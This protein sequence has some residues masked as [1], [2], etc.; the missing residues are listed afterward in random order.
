MAAVSSWTEIHLAARLLQVPPER[1]EG[2]VTKR[3]MVSPKGAGKVGGATWS[4]KSMSLTLS[5]SLVSRTHPTAGSPDLCQWKVPLM[6][7]NLGDG[8]WS[9]VSALHSRLN[10]GAR[11]DAL[12]KTLYTRLFTWLL[13]QISAQLS[14]PREADSVATIAVVDAFGFEVTP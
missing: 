11:R 12:A 14:P 6:P 7:G 2:A 9:Q 5:I 3:V 4:T 13:K 10:Y 1:L 8:G